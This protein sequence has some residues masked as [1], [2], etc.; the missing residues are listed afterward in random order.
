LEEVAAADAVG[1]ACGAGIAGNGL[2]FGGGFRGEAFVGVDVEHPGVLEGDV[3]Q[4]P[5]LMGSPV[6]EGALHNSCT[7]RMRNDTCMVSAK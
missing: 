2:E 5:V 1:N 7:L 4:T 3:A 6:V